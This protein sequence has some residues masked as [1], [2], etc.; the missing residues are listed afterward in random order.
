MNF[1]GSYIEGCVALGNKGSSHEALKEDLE[2]R[3]G[4]MCWITEGS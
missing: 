1:L 2:I 4:K 3:I